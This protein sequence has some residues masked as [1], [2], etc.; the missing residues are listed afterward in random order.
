V[1]VGDRV[2]GTLDVEDERVGAFD[3]GDRELLDRVAAAMTGLDAA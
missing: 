3:D 1:L 2:V